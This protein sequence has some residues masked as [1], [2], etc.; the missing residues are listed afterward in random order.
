[1]D[2]RQELERATI[3]HQALTTIVGGT[4]GLQFETDYMQELADCLLQG[5]TPVIN[6]S[7]QH[8]S[9]CQVTGRERHGGLLELLGQLAVIIYWLEL[10]VCYEQDITAD[11]L[12]GGVVS[13]AEEVSKDETEAQGQVGE[14]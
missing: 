2:Y 9:E 7:C 6:V 8:D 5:F 3:L 13:E 11:D 10:E 14:V 4:T 1:M 12:D